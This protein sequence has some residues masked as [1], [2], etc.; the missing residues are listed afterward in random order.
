MF[1]TDKT[2][3]SFPVAIGTSLSLESVFEGRLAPYDAA[4][5]IPN[6]VNISH[7]SEAW[8]NINTLFRNLIGALPNDGIF[9]STPEG[10]A[11]D[12]Y[13]E[14]EVITSLFKNEGNGIC[15]PYYY[16]CS[17]NK[18]MT[19]Y[20]AK[21]ITFRH[22]STDKQKLFESK[23]KETVKYLNKL[24][25][26]LLANLDSSLKPKTNVG[27]ALVLTHIPYDL[28]SHNNFKRFDL[29]ESHTG[30]LK[31]KY[32]FSGKYQPLGSEIMDQLPF[33][34]KLLMVFGD[35]I[36]IVPADIRIRRLLLEIA[37]NRE[38]TPYTT[39]A[40]VN[41]F[42]DA[43]IKELYLKEWLMSL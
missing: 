16:L 11:H 15:A 26:E 20:T 9:N 13:E 17:Y 33:L 32:E 28:V 30:K 34:E 4:R 6:K 8:F 12:L 42:I 24:H 37:K 3:S 40:K 31:T 39:E 18:V 25:P 1:Y 29:L 27:N 43:D 7:Y 5:E 35:K 22:A 36:M 14:I 10:L 38:W 23:Y 2:I 21:K 41:Y 19:K